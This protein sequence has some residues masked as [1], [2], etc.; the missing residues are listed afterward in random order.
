MSD[1]L[2][3]ENTVDKRI[4]FFGCTKVESLGTMS[5][6]P[7]IILG[8]TYQPVILQVRHGNAPNTAEGYLSFCRHDGLTVFGMCDNNKQG[9]LGL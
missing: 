4:A 1:K 9:F 8:C 3:L 2:S 5:T 6:S 7:A